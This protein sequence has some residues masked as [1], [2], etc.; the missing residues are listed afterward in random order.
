MG[1][2]KDREPFVGK[3]EDG[4]LTD[5]INAA[6]Q[7]AEYKILGDDT[8]VGRIP[9]FD[10]RWANAPTL[11]AARQELHESLEDWILV[12]LRRGHP[13][14]A[15]RHADLA[16]HVD[17][18]ARRCNGSSRNGIIGKS[19]G[20]RYNMGELTS[21]WGGRRILKWLVRHS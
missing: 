4:M 17:V 10:G 6:M 15:C 16:T 14:P 12:G 11:E 5:Y 21:R 2:G 20:N 3:A 1:F 18:S 8:Y 9:G 7:R 19:V 13:L